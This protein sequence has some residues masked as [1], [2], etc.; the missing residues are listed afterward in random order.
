MNIESDPN[1]AI[2]SRLDLDPAHEFK[3][4]WAGSFS[5]GLRSRSKTTDARRNSP[6]PAAACAMWM[7]SAHRVGYGTRK[8]QWLKTRVAK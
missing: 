4:S 5:G 8:L 2:L 7:G 1:A 6:I 3:P